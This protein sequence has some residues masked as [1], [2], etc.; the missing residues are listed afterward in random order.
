ML[1][2]TS[3]AET[4][5]TRTPVDTVAAIYAAFGR[6]DLPG[7]F[8]LLHAEVDWGSTVTAPG[9]EL[10]PRVRNGLGHAAAERYFGGVAQLEMHVF[11]VGRL[12]VDNE[13]VVAEIRFAA[14][15]RVTAKHAALDELH[16]WTVRNGLVV[17]YRPYLDTAALI[18]IFRPAT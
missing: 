4:P 14:T 17:R 16:H 11:E 7:L 9:G 13:V 5:G 8:E 18:E 12:L 15:H 3:T 10:V 2:T 6:D 1:T